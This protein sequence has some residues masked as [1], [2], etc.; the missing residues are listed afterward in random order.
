MA[1]RVQP[2]GVGI[3]GSR[4]L[5]DS[6]RDQIREVVS[7]LL[8]HSYHIHSGGAVGADQFALEAVI[9]LG[10]FRHSA[11]FSPD[12]ILPM[13]FILSSM[14]HVSFHGIK[15]LLY[16]V[17]IPKSVN[18]VPGIKCKVCA[19]NIPAGGEGGIRSFVSPAI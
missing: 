11:I 18:H 4:T 6:Y 16:E 2:R 1:V 8:E 3:V 13:N 15:I 9:S 14:T 10:G 12:N 19:R 17:L 5:P 7:Y